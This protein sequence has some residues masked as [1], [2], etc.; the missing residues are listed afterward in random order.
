MLARGLGGFLDGFDDAWVSAAATDVA[1]QS[2]LNFG[3]SGV[4]VLLQ[5]G[6]AAHDHAGSAV[7][8]LKSFGVEEGLLTWMVAAGF[9]EDFDSGDGF[10]CGSGNGSYAR[11]T[12][13]AIEQNGAGAALAF[14]AAVLGAGEAEMVAE[15]G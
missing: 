12:R 15:N 2:L 8:T 13:R 6:D 11:T 4:G 10:S 5:K 7:G 14:A 9:F 1:V 3:L